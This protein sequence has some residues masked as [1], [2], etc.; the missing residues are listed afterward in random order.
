MAGGVTDIASMG[1]GLDSSTYGARNLKI[2]QAPGYVAIV[3]PEYEDYRIIPLN[4]HVGLSKFRTYGGNTFGHWDGNTLV[5]EITNVRYEYPIVPG[6][7]SGRNYPGTGETLKVT[8]RYTPIDANNLDYRYTIEDSGVYTRPYTV[9]V[10][11]F[12][13]D[14]YQD[15]PDLCQENNLRDMGGIFITAR[16]D[17][18]QAAENMREVQRERD[19]WFQLRKKAAIEEA[20]RQSSKSNK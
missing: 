12:R 8:E 17:E 14:A 20:N 18:F 6:Y 5:V 2:V 7:F 19:R 13:D 10:D 15:L 4:Q 3:S 16:A 1:D 9:Q 11:M